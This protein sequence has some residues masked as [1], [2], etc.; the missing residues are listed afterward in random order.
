MP[1]E[2]RRFGFPNSW[3]IIA[4]M[5]AITAVLSWVIP[6]G[7][8]DYIVQDIGGVMRRT[9]VDGTFHYIDKATVKPTDFLGLFS[10]FYRGCVEAA[11]IFFVMLF[12]TG[13]FSIMVETGAFHAGIS[14]LMKRFGKNAMLIAVSLIFFFGA[15]GS[16]FGMLS[17]FYGF[18]PFMAALGVA[19]GCDAMFGVAILAVG[20]FIGFMSATTNPYTLAIAQTLSG[21]PLYSAGLWHLFCFAVFMGSSALYILR[22]GR[23]VSL[24][25]EKSLLYGHPCLTEFKTTELNS[26][27]LDTKM[28]LVITDMAVT[29][30]TL[31]YGLIK[32]GWGY[33]EL[34]ALFTVMS[35]IAAAI[36]RWSPDK[37]CEVFTESIKKMFWGAMLTGLAK[38]MIVIMQDAQIID[39]ITYMLT[40]LLRHTPSKL[41]AQLMLLIHTLINFPI[42]SGSGKALITMPIMAPL[43]DNLGLTRQVA[44]TAFLFGDGLTKLLWPTGGCVI[45]CALSG[46][47]YEKWLKWFLPLC[48][49]LYLEQMLLLQLAV[50]IGL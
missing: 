28:L 41:S 36:C 30:I 35:V 19:V 1:S 32:L 14:A 17:E 37:Y 40:N 25:P 26:C 48:G 10:V 16:A 29:L 2:R 21:L 13:T 8:Y 50:I 47:P 43:A 42:S 9:A 15:C 7:Q 20:E 38:A 24:H 45:I 6:S 49:I 46:I 44:C 23:K 3:I 22:Y 11:D 4:V 12:C 33:T 39:T 31:M 18:Y 5:A 34:C 27:K